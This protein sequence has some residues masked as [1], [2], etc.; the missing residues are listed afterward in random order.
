MAD[1]AASASNS[2]TSGQPSRHYDYVIV[3][4]GSA[5]C[6]LANRLS[7]DPENSVLL[8]EAGG[9]DWNP[10]IHIPIGFG[11]IWK[12]RLHDWRYHTDPEP[13]LC[14]RRVMYLRGKVLGGSS[15][16]N[17]QAFTR[18]ERG[19]YDRWAREGATGWSFDDT[20]PYFKR[21][22]S[23]CEGENSLRGGS[24]PVA[25][26]WSASPDPLFDAWCNAAKASGLRTDYDMNN[27]R[28][29]G[30][31]QVQF[32]IDRGRRASAA[33]AYLHPASARPNL[34]VLT[35]TLTTR[36]LIE[37]NRAIGIEIVAAGRAHIIHAGREVIVSA[38]TLNT[39]ALLMLSGVGPAAHLESLGI[40]PIVN[41]P[42]G[43]NLQDHWA[44]P[45]FYERPEPGYFHG[46]MRADR[47]TLAMLG[48]QL[49]RTGPGTVV[50]TNVF[51]FA[52]TRPEEQV[53][54][55]EFLLMPTAPTARLWFP[56]LRPAYKDAFGIRPAIMH[57]A[58]RGQVTLRSTDPREPPRFVFN[59]LQRQEDMDTLKRGLAMARDLAASSSMAPFRG[60]E[61]LP[62]PDVRTESDLE[63]FIR[64]SVIPVYHAVGTCAMGDHEGSVTDPQLRV[65]GVEHLRV[66]DA[67]AMPD[68]ITGH[69]NA[70]VLMMAERAAD[71]ILG[72]TQIQ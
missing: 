68:L 21:V 60:R 40:R 43:Q 53:P 31:G 39:P 47:M 19:D 15:S 25:V 32:S 45:V 1:S 48:A 54:D 12:H 49:F 3:G 10:L 18:G 23:W 36:V 35:R 46:R 28:S 16:I 20:L 34:T 14:D 64:R 50:P 67:S 52:K 55:I 24:G 9:S 38:G 22:E 59:A 7:E 5:G 58:S 57:P 61:I 30:F 27:G 44:A 33:N 6:V 72:R 51:G 8:V 71:L 4:A 13:G 17:V 29:D 63:Q 41:L 69:I 2:H 66:V 11:L 56:L 37:N 26:S 42:V 70:G 62:G 65:R